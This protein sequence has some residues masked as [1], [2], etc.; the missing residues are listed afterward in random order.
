M[1]QITISL[2]APINC[3]PQTCTRT[4]LIDIP[5]AKPRAPVMGFS[6]VATPSVAVR[7][8]PIN[9][10]YSNRLS[11]TAYRFRNDARVDLSANTRTVTVCL[12]NGHSR[13]AQT[14]Q[15]MH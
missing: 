1:Q 6:A 2:A 11:D 10:P 13:L 3:S 5:E 15:H 9:M 4:V 7:T 14:F 8:Q 12:E